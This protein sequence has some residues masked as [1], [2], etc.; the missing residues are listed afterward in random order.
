VCPTNS[1]ASGR[2]PL[3]HRDLSLLLVIGA[4]ADI[5][6][7]FVDRRELVSIAGGAALSGSQALDLEALHASQLALDPS[8]A[9]STA[10]ARARK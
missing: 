5:G 4:A 3:V 1:R 8:E 10:L 7:A 9:R 2:R 6:R